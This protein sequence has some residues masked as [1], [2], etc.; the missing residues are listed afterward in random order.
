MPKPK[1]APYYL[2]AYPFAQLAATEPLSEI[3]ADTAKRKTFDLV[4]SRD[5]KS[6]A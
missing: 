2:C 3:R 4:P 1:S 5:T 6:F